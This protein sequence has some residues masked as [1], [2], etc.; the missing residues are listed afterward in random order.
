MP[1]S[2]GWKNL[3]PT[4]VIEFIQDAYW[5]TIRE[6]EN[7]PFPRLVVWDGKDAEIAQSY[8]SAVVGHARKMGIRPLT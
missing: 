7:T 5:L 1:N 2:V 3:K 8:L 4:D 6:G